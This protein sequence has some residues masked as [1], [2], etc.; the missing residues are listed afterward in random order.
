MLVL[1][2][3]RNGT[4]DAAR[5]ADRSKGIGDTPKESTTPSSIGFTFKVGDI[6]ARM[7]S[8]RIAQRGVILMRP[9][10][11][12]PDRRS[13]LAGSAAAGAASVLPAQ[14]RAAAEANAIR[15]FRVNV[16]KEQLID[17]RRR[18]NA[19]KWPEQETV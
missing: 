13:L 14:A 17:L 11:S 15:P 12:S 6:C 5:R 8:N 19:T 16:P 4:A 10:S 1:S 9:T 3:T 7:R 18:I 2:E